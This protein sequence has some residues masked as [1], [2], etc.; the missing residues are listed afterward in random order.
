MIGGILSDIYTKEERNTPMALFSGAAFFG[1]GLG[2]LVS[3]FIAQNSSWRWIYFCQAIMSAV[4]VLLVAIF[5]LETRGNVLLRRK[6]CALNN[7]YD[8]VE[9]AG[10]HFMTVSNDGNWVI[11][12]KF[13]WKAKE[14][15]ERETLRKT[16]I[17][18]LSRPFR[19][20]S[21]PF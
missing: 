8:T 3:G 15:D 13:R 2:P 18:S 1:T 19:I 11:Q 14:D 9:E 21:N 20:V 6:A 16:I 7:Y 12:E 17:V 10:H 4:V 5:F